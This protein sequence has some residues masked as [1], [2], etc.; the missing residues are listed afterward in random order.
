MG[1]LLCREAVVIREPRQ[2]GEAL[3]LRLSLGGGGAGDPGPGSQLQGQTSAGRGRRTPPERALLGEGRQ[4]DRRSPGPR[5]F[6]TGWSSKLRQLVTLSRSGA[7]TPVH[8]CTY[9]H[10]MHNTGGPHTHNTHPC[11]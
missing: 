8:T 6:L 3:A 2:E 1:A 10:H 9:A 4:P 7:H 11:I 5:G